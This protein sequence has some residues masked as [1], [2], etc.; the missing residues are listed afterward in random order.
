MTDNDFLK[1]CD[2]VPAFSD[3]SDDYLVKS[4]EEAGEKAEAEGFTIIYPSETEILVDLDDEAAQLSFAQRFKDVRE[5][6]DKTP[7]GPLR[8]TSTWASKSGQGR[9]VV[10]DLGAVITETSERIAWQALLGSDHKREAIAILRKRGG[11]PLPSRLF[12]PV[13]KKKG[14]KLPTTPAQDPIDLF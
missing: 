14:K 11:V 8:I 10:V 7:L 2:A 5:I 1:E 3:T 4:F 6:L 13:E 9:H 12:K